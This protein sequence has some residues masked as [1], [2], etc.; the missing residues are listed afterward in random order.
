M[1][2][3]FDTWLRELQQAQKGGIDLPAATRGLRWQEPI[4]LEGNWTGATLAG[5]VRTAP[6][7]AGDPLATFAIT[8]PVVT[9]NGAGWL[10]TWTAVL[11]AGTV[12]NSTGVLP[13][14]AD[15]DGVERFPCS[16]LLTPLGG[17][18]ALL[19]GAALPVLGKV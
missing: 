8:G 15:F 5:V 16:F 4:E 11:V 2:T 10:S 7:A 19:I 1:S 6:D 14:D 13:A 9:P 17:N 18:Q 12:A 3:N